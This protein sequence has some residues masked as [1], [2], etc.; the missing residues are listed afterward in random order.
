MSSW[1]TK[2]RALCMLVALEDVSMKWNWTQGS[3]F[4]WKDSSHR[5]ER[6]KI[7]SVSRLC[8]C[9]TL[10]FND[11]S[12]SIQ[13]PRLTPEVHAMQLC[14]IPLSSIIFIILC[15]MELFFIKHAKKTFAAHLHVVSFHS[16][17]DLWQ[18]TRCTFTSTFSLLIKV[19]P[20]VHHISAC[21][22]KEW[23]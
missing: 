14:H 18:L 5:C 22:K 9:P 12:A 17:T 11:N 15:N 7:D 6:V 1:E 2:T 21:C 23:M 13:P 10:P 19:L 16:P 4:L 8:C 3:S 20:S